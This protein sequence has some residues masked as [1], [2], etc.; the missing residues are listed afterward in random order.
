MS[1][2]VSAVRHG[3]QRLIGVKNYAPYLVIPA[4]AGIQRL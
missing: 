4:Q 1:P 3:P 2:L